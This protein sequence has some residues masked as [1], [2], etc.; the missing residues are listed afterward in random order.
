MAE[1]LVVTINVKKAHNNHLIG[2]VIKTFY[3]PDTSAFTVYENDVLVTSLDGL[4]NPR[5]T[6]ENYARVMS[7]FEFL[8]SPDVITYF[9][10]YTSFPFANSRTRLASGAGVNDLTLGVDSITAAT[11][12]NNDGSVVLFASG[13]NTPFQYSKDGSL[14]QSSE[15]FS[16]L[17]SGNYT[18]YVKDSFSY[19]DTVTVNVPSFEIPIE[20]STHGAKYRVD[21][22][23]SH[24]GISSPRDGIKHRIEIQERGYGGSVSTIDGGVDPVII[25]ARAEGSV[26]GVD[27]NVIGHELTITILSS[28]FGQFSELAKGDEHKYLVLYYIDDSVGKDGTDYNIRFR[29][30]INPETFQEEYGSPPYLVS[31]IASDRLGDLK[32]FN[33]YESGVVDEDGKRVFQRVN[34]LLKQSTI[35]DKCLKKLRMNQGYRIAIDMFE[36][37]FN[38]TSTDTPIHQAYQECSTFYN[39]DDALNCDE[40]ISAILK[41][42]GAFLFSWNDF[43]YIVREEEIKETSVSFVEFATIGGAG[44]SDSYS[45]RITFKASGNNTMFR[46][47]GNQPLEY[48]RPVNQIN[49]ISNGKKRDDGG[50]NES[51]S[52]NTAIFNDDVFV[53]YRDYNLITSQDLNSSQFIDGDDYGWKIEFN[54]SSAYQNSSSYIR[55][56]KSISYLSLDKIKIEFEFN[57]DFARARASFQFPAPPYVPFK[58][59]LKL[60][61]NYL[62]SDGTWD[63]TDTVNQYFINESD[64][65]NGSFNKFSIEAQM[66]DDAT[67]EQTDDYEFLLYPPSGGEYDISSTDIT[68]AKDDLEEVTTTTLENGTRRIVR[69]TQGTDY[70]YYYF[71]LQTTVGDAAVAATKADLVEVRPDDYTTSISKRWYKKGG[72]GNAIADE[73][74]FRGKTIIKNINIKTFPSGE[75]AP[76]EFGSS[77][78]ISDENTLELDVNLDTF[79]LTNDVVNDENIYINHTRKSDGSPTTVW[80]KD[81][82]IEEKVRQEH[83]KD[84]LFQLYKTP[85]Y[86]MGISLY[87]DVEVNL[88]KSFY[89]AEDFER[90]FIL[91]GIEINPKTGQHTGEM[92]E[93]FSSE[94][95]SSGDFNNDYDTDND[96]F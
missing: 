72:W 6:Q 42:Y 31:F 18:F 19:I 90:V 61:T 92:L 14:Y 77:F 32:N 17:Y 70:V 10:H 43:F 20:N 48:T 4:Y 62:Q 74:P 52:K 67:P 82:G 26:P 71:E 33:F 95:Q 37:S 83:L 3:D 91:N 22:I 84:R 8:S 89:V 38:A 73:S 76:D 94:T 65:N 66:P 21:F 7:G 12:G 44:S 57:F 11:T 35:I 81:G 45:P 34:G 64:I 24:N 58:W 79:D 36:D 59:K 28:T 51:W 55:N 25:R 56:S 16:N 2:D 60:G 27:I 40:V 30:Y 53:G 13:T 93:L 1:T 85:R 47:M 29:G 5:G 41:P 63:T 75:E 86:K 15:T 88:T 80:V 39:D 46:F 68:D 9:V 69:F 23:E 78:V 54:A 96:Y 87:S 49:V 50:I